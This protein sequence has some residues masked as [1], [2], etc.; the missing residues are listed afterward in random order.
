MPAGGRTFSCSWA[1]CEASCLSVMSSWATA[2]ASVN[3]SMNY[4]CVCESALVKE[5]DT[6]THT[7]EC[8]I[9]LTFKYKMYCVD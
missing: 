2:F 9:I 6:H 3:F 4:V 7:R 8:T 5:I 1:F